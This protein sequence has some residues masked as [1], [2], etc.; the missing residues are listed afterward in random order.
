MGPGGTHEDLGVLGQRLLVLVVVHGR[1]EDLDAVVLDV[2]E[3]LPGGRGAR[4][5]WR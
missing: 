5:I 3:D 2:G 1:A 4:C